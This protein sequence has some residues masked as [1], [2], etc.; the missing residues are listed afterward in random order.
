M[1]KG[2]DLSVHPVDVAPSKARSLGLTQTGE[3]QEFNEIG[4]FL[5]P[6]VVDLRSDFTHDR[7]KLLELNTTVDTN[8]NILLSLKRTIKDS[9]EH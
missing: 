1:P 7:P 9:Y 6:G 3:A 2:N 4:A 5:C 8:K